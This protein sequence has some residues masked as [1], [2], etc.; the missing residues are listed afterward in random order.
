MSAIAH[1]AAAYRAATA[2]FLEVARAVPEADLD[3]HHPQGWSA[4]Q[5]IHHVAD[6]E[7]Q[8]YSR[9]RRLLAEA[10]PTIQGY[11]E[12]AWAKCATLGYT[13]LPVAVSLA[14]FEA[15]RTASAGIIDRLTPADLEKSGHH[16][17]RGAL[18][19]AQWLDMYTRHPREHTEQLRRALHGEL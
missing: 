3:V 11:D 6:S 8:S 18:T 19:V 10:E 2:E 9:I 15:V 13:E 14:V 1:A 4:R 7:T 17:E 16:T 12:E 5:V